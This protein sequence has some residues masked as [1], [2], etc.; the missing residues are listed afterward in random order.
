MVLN[1]VLMPLDTRLELSVCVFTV[2]PAAP[3]I[4]T[5]MLSC[6]TVGE[7]SASKSRSGVKR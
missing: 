1:P 3:S 2:V 6:P 5:S 7:A 4:L